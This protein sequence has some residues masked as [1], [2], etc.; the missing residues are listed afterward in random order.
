MESGRELDALVAEKVMG[1]KLKSMR[2][3]PCPYCG[4]EMRYCGQRSRCT[5]CS[6]WRDGPAKEYSTEIAPAWEV[7]EK[8]VELGFDG[9]N[10]GDDEVYFEDSSTSPSHTSAA[11]NV[12]KPYRFG[13]AIPSNLWDTPRAICLAALK[14][15][16]QPD[17]K[18]D[19]V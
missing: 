15:V 16:A 3:A 2:Y 4:M 9:W 13:A 5:T 10:V 18:K 7:I 6:E 17:P 8:M 19:D 1:L 11:A 14:A 12:E